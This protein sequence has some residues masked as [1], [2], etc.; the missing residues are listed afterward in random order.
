MLNLTRVILLRRYLVYL[1]YLSVA[2]YGIL[3]PKGIYPLFIPIYVVLILSVLLN[4]K[5]LTLNLSKFSV[6]FS[7]IF[8]F[9]ILFLDFFFKGSEES[10]S[11]YAH[12]FYFIIFNL[13][14]KLLVSNLREIKFNHI[15]RTVLLVYWVLVGTCILDFFLMTMGIN[16][17]SFI[18]SL[19][20]VDAGIIGF[21]RSRGAFPEPTDLGAAITI[22]Y[23]MAIGFQKVNNKNSIAILAFW[24]IC[25]VMHRS[26]MALIS[27]VLGHIILFL[28]EKR[29]FKLSKLFYLVIV[30]LSFLCIFSILDSYFDGGVSSST[31]DKILLNDENK[32]SGRVEIY[33]DVL[34]LVL[35]K[36]SLT[37]WMFGKSLGTFS[38]FSVVNYY[39]QTILELG[40]FGLCLLLCFGL[41]IWRQITTIGL[42]IRPYFFAAGAVI[43]LQ[44][45]SNT[46]F[47]FPH[48]WMFFL[49]IFWVK[50]YNFKQ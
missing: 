39:L 23:F 7:M 44:L 26:G 17:Y 25:F 12:T 38:K 37:D 43:I 31:F 33:S 28:F 40:I 16:Y 47:Y 27:F 48:I 13:S 22:F 34:N 19:I 30:I 42:V 29:K 35:S 8:F 21:P 11:L 32:G 2:F 9:Y 18:P 45:F 20:P 6:V 3:N 49:T 36:Y 4:G 1:L 5:Y 46:G 50:S 41:Y 15:K 14:I 24:I 10:K